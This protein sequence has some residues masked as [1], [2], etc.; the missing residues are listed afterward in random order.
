MKRLFIITALSVWTTVYLLLLAS[1]HVYASDDCTFSVKFINTT[2]HKVD[3][4][5][6][7]VSHPY[8]YFKSINMAGGELDP[9]ETIQLKD[10]YKCGTYYV[11]WSDEDAN[12]IHAF[13]QIED[14]VL[15]LTPKQP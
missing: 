1:G 12:H 6:N 14:G 4:L 8:K 2:D 15:V 3:Y 11:L 7:W 13:T 9:G 5:F 10:K